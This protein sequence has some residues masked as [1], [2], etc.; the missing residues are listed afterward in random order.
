[1]CGLNVRR[2]LRCHA[3]AVAGCFLVVASAS[4]GPVEEKA[5]RT[6]YD[7]LV[8]Q[9]EQR[10]PLRMRYQVDRFQSQAFLAAG[11]RPDAQG[12]L[13]WSEDVEYARKGEKTWQWVHTSHPDYKTE[14]ARTQFRLFNGEIEVT[15]G[16][17]EKTYQISRKRSGMHE[18]QLPT[19]ITGED[20]VRRLLQEWSKG[21]S[22]ITQLTIQEKQGGD[23]RPVLSCSWVYPLSKWTVRIEF[24]AGEWNV[25]KSYETIHSDGTLLGR[26]VVEEYAHA[27]GVTYPK[28]GTH[29][30]YDQLRHLLVRTSFEV[31]SAETR[32]SEIP[33]SLFT[34]VFPDDAVIW[35]V[36][37]KVYVRNA[38]A[39]QSHL[40][41]ALRHLGPRK[42]P[43]AL[44]I[45]TATGSLAALVLTAWLLRRWRRRAA[46]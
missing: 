22:S 10:N 13:H 35:D 17:Q 18:A 8:V 2:V 45:G 3:A 14:W 5:L 44:W 21:L 20:E 30:Q 28:R 12:D 9:E 36:E 39:A 7:T 41:E 42:T 25:L 26:H 46:H 43:W 29:E 34:M 19:E 4:G 16:A 38:D 1:M 33:D 32:A 6:I 11:I 40:E 23:G 31:Q 37:N 24:I 15:P 27:G